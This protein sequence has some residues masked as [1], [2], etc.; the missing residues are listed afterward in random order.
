MTIRTFYPP[1]LYHFL[2]DIAAKH[3]LAVKEVETVF[4]RTMAEEL[5][6]V[7]D[8]LSVGFA[9][10]DGKP[11]CKGCWTRME[12]TKPP[13]YIGRQIK[14]PG[15]FRPLKTFLT[16]EKRSRSEEEKNMMNKAK[17]QQQQQKDDSLTV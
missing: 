10:S 3:K 15:Q 14:V 2:Y 5:G 7:C 1:E 6:F 8:H 4:L 17:E 9:K 13:V 16:W 12:Q 11:Y